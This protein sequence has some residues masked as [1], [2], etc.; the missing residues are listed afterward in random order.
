VVNKSAAF[1]ESATES[2]DQP[3]V[4]RFAGQS[5][6]NHTLF[7]ASRFDVN[8]SYEQHNKAHEQKVRKPGKYVSSFN[9]KRSDFIGL[10]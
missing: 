3:S 4:H 1:R 9:Q 6:E 10:D 7:Q 5:V 2:V 8:V